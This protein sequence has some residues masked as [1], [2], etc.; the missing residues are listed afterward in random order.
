[1]IA[2]ALTQG[3]CVYGD[4]KEEAIQNY[5]SEKTK[6]KTSQKAEK[7]ITSALEELKQYIGDLKDYDPTPGKHNNGNAKIIGDL[8][9][10]IDKVRQGLNHVG[11]EN[12]EYP[13]RDGKPQEYIEYNDG[14]GN[15]VK[16]TK[17]GASVEITI[18]D[19]NG[20]SSK[21]FALSGNP[22]KNDFE[23]FFKDANREIVIGLMNGFIKEFHKAVEIREDS[24][25]D[26]KMDYISEINKDR[27]INFFITRYSNHKRDI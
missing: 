3:V 7:E 11:D 14:Q 24:F 16:L 18:K 8:I 17:G 19:V 2:V 9:E 25:V 5:R 6:L 13:D 21:D 1:M 26:Q 27:T 22:A 23:T 20:G 12:V 15:K 4:A 10:R